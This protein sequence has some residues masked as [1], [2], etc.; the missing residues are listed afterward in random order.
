M[1]FKLGDPSKAPL[2]VAIA[3]RGGRDVLVNNIAWILRRMPLFT[4]PGDGTY[5][6][7][8]VHVEDLAR[9]CTDA[10]ALTGDVVID[11]AGPCD[12]VAAIRLYQA[13]FSL[14]AVR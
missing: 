2:L 7:Q 13:E 5:P 9:I 4:L 3:Q 11:A 10:S 8:P 6:V 1:I 14:E 12:D